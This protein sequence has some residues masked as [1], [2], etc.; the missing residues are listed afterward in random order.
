MR[1]FYLRHEIV[2]ITIASSVLYIAVGMHA[3]FLLNWIVGPI[4]PITCVWFVPPLVRRAFGWR[5]PLP[6]QRT[7]A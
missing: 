1:G 7:A 6:H 2:V 4:W 3:R 5:D